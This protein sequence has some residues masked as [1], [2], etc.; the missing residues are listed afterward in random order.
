MTD[1][2][3]PSEWEQTDRQRRWL[4][5]LRD[6]I[7]YWTRVPFLRVFT[8]WKIRRIRSEHEAE[9]QRRLKVRTH[10]AQAMESDSED[11]E[12]DRIVYSER[13]QVEDLQNA[14]AEAE[15]DWFLARALRQRIEKPF[16]EEEWEGESIRE[17]RRLK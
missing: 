4:R 7:P 10:L 17:P 14:L 1:E 9:T 6:C 13:V 2:E 11:R 12:F 16:T 5:L 15:T 3:K 8:R